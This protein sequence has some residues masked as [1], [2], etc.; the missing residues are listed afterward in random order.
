MI[1]FGNEEDAVVIDKNNL[2]LKLVIMTK[3]QQLLIMQ[4]YHNLIFIQLQ[5]Q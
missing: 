4:I 2:Y 3:I 1:K 5:Q